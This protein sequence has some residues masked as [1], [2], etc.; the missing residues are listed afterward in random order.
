V[1]FNVP[2]SLETRSFHL[3][4]LNHVK[5]DGA[6]LHGCGFNMAGPGEGEASTNTTPL[7][8]D[9]RRAK[10]PLHHESRDSRVIEPLV[11]AS[12]AHPTASGR[13]RPRCWLDGC[14]FGF[15]SELR[16][17]GILYMCI[18]TYPT[19]GSDI[20]TVAQS[21]RRVGLVR[22]ATS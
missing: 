16:P 5:F 22:S 15:V 20:P 18:R 11:C 7:T 8:A 1:S 12:R 19:R 3:L 17:K 6:M 21:S 13:I 9:F 2:K 4:R 14:L 10:F